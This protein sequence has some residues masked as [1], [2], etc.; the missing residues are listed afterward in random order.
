MLLPKI[1]ELF[2][3]SLS[4]LIETPPTKDM[5]YRREMT[6][7]ELERDF[8]LVM[9]GGGGGGRGEG[10]GREGRWALSDS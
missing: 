4:I 2:R 8:L 7:L 9:I 1:L 10:G 3:K 5:G 6:G